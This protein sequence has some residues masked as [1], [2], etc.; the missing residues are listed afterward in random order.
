MLRRFANKNT[1]VAIFVTIC[2][3][4]F[5]QTL[6]IS[7][8]KVAATEQFNPYPWKLHPFTSDGCSMFPDAAGPYD[9]TQCCVKH[10]VA[11]WHGGTE[12][13]RK[14]ADEELASC[15]KGIVGE[16]MGLLMF[17]GVRLGGGAEHNTSWRWGYGW[18]KDRGIE[19][20]S[21]EEKEE[22]AKY[23]N[24]LDLKPLRYIMNPETYAKMTEAAPDRCAAMV[25]TQLEEKYNRSADE[26]WIV[27]I[28]PARKSDPHELLVFHPNAPKGYILAK[29]VSGHHVWDCIILDKER[30]TYWQSQWAMRDQ[31]INPKLKK[32]L[33]ANFPSIKDAEKWVE[34]SAPALL[35][36]KMEITEVGDWSAFHL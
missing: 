8:R 35:E 36:I 31:L 4:F 30:Q 26:F 29:S 12:S 27:A 11:Y 25:K 16:F 34:N 15:V 10:D 22:I 24:V 5:Y 3:A 7:N 18:I 13:E 1:F 9:W 6:S 2:S 14:V 32:W 23:G 19:P 21:K 28:E 17:Q 33:N 20:L